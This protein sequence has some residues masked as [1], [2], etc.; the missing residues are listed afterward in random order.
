M[1]VAPALELRSVDKSFGAVTALQGASLIARAGAL[2][3]LLGEN[4]AGKTTLLRIAAGFLRPDSGE[5]IIN[6]TSVRW[7]SR[8]E[9]LRAGIG[10]VEQHFSLVPAM[11]VA[12]N[13]LLATEGPFSRY[14]PRAAAE[15]V[16][17]I[18]QSANLPVE[19]GALVGDLSVAAQQRTE[20]VKALATDA[21][22]LILDEPTAVLTPIESEDLFR[23][24]RSFVETGRTAV[25]ITHRIREA[26]QHGDSL[27]VLR[28]GRTVLTGDRDELSRDQVVSAIMGAP[29]STSVAPRR[30]R[31]T[32]PAGEILAT[33]RKVTVA[34]DGEVSRLQD[35][36]L[37]IRR[38]E[39]IGVAG[40]EGSGQ[41]ELL[42]LLAGRLCPTS[43][44]V[45][46]PER[47]GF[48]PE[49]RLRD[50]LVATMSLTENQAI[51]GLG[52]RAGLID[53]SAMASAT[54]ASIDAF[55]VRTRDE[56]QIAATLSGGNQQK[57]VLARE[58]GEQPSMIVAENPTRGL[59]VRSSVD[60]MAQ[61]A[62]ASDAG[63]AVVLYSSD[64]EDLI[65]FVDRLL[66]CFSGTVK[67]VTPDFEAAGS[68][69]LGAR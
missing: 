66:V 63:S 44:S 36:D 13:V 51:R 31:S 46:L 14:S 12:E 11:T 37:E 33:L 60:V 20:I 21:S 35:V 16:A 43:G 54:R 65:G 2:H 19:P 55:S 18:A 53:W 10:A 34:D 30:L 47:V 5:V 42:R 4:G 69:M 1:T 50:A 57:F 58:L 26:L 9:A 29:T 32:L 23:W 62:T 28:G 25:V 49:D 27:A 15:R 41:H 24:L 3:M 6:G 56:R 68:A 39:I 48:I 17:R 8:A 40:V 7:R 45:S 22:L 64:L 61:L 59:D 67:E 52:A 38:G